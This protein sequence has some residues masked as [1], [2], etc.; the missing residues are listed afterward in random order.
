M[1]GMVPSR[2]KKE[3]NTMAANIQERDIQ[4][5]LSQAWHGLTNIVESITKENAGINYPMETRPLFIKKTD[6]TEIE[7]DHKQIV[8]LDDELPIGNPVS[9]GYCLIENSRIWDM[10]QDALLGMKHQIVSV[11]TV[12]D[13]SK[14]FISVKLDE[15]FTAASRLTEPLLNLIW[16]HGGNISLIARSGFTVTVCENTFNVNLGRKGKEFNL[17]LKHTKN[18]LDR[19]QNMNEAIQNYAGV[20]AEFK[21]AMDSFE[22]VSC[23]EENARKIIGGVIVPDS[24]E[25][26]SKVAT[27]T[28]NTIDRMVTLFEGGAGNKG[29]NLSDVFNAATDYYSHESSGGDNNRMKQFVSSEFG[30][31]QRMK[32]TFFN[33]LSNE[34][35]LATVKARG[36]KVMLAIANQD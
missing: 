22:S 23:D 32:E 29:K 25:R 28:R 12:A 33:V 17:S 26:D 21:A 20:V 7:T 1:F 35:E 19:I 5:G 9:S 14:G 4:T 8:S 6:G 18:A 36:E 27:R 31:G 15:A 11:G 30:A 24:F 34:D 2:N 16:G 10:V 3:K 13:R